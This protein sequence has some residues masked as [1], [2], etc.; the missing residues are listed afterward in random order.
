LEQELSELTDAE[1]AEDCDAEG[2]D[3]GMA[4][5][6]EPLSTAEQ[7]LLEVKEEGEM[8][9][10]EERSLARGFLK[11]EWR[12]LKDRLIAAGG[13]YEPEKPAVDEQPET[14]EIEDGD[15]EKEE[16][17]PEDEEDEKEEPPPEPREG[18]RLYRSVPLMPIGGHIPHAAR[19]RSKTAPR[20]G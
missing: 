15:D 8:R 4:Q 20:K 5:P 17:P 1:E 3:S 10:A 16:P 6:V 14:V 7:E 19:P 9:L 11:R 12:S 18:R 13:T 2:S